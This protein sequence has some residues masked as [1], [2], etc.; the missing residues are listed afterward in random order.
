VVTGGK[1]NILLTEKR[2]VEK[3]KKSL[4][5]KRKGN[6]KMDPMIWGKKIT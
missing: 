2:G 1:E 5:Q 4:D 3:G 6:W